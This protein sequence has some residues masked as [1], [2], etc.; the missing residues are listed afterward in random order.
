M[1]EVFGPYTQAIKSLVVMSGENAV[2][3]TF[4]VSQLDEQQRSALAAIVTNS[5]HPW[6]IEYS[7]RLRVLDD[8]IESGFRK[9]RMRRKLIEKRT[10][11]IFWAKLTKADKIYRIVRATIFYAMALLLS[12]IGLAAMYEMSFGF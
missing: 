6:M 10:R 9:K 1:D 4:L 8:R 7:K 5:S 12:L 3:E 11:A 2:Y